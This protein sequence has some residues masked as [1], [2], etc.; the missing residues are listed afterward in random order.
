MGEVTEG[1]RRVPMRVWVAVFVVFSFVCSGGF[2][3][4]DMV[5]GSGPGFVL[6]LLMILPFVWG[7]PQALVCS[8]LGSAL[9]EDGGLYRWSRRANGEFMG[10]QTGWWWVLSIFVDS[11]VYIALTC[12]YMQ[13]WFGF[14]DWVRWGIA[15]GLIAIFAYINI[16]GIQLAASVLIVFQVIVFIPF[17]ALAVIGIANWHHNPFSV[18]LLP[19]NSLLGGVGVALSV[20]IWMYSGF[21][22]LST[23]AGEIER[24][25]KVIPRALMITLPIVIGF[26]VLS[27]LGGLADVGRYT[28]WGTSGALD[29]MGVGRVVGGQI[30]RYLFFAAMFAGN[31]ALFLAFLAAGARPSFTLSKDKLLPKFLSKTH[32]KYGTPFAAILLMAGVDCILVRSGF[33]TLIVIDVFLLMLAHITIY[34]SAIRL[35]VNEPDMERPFK[36]GLKTPAFIAMCAVPITVAVFAM[37]PWGNGWNYFIWGT[38]AALTGPPAYFIFKRIYGGQRALDAERA[39]GG[40]EPPAA[41]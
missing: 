8:E 10:F 23:M 17:A 24:P 7:L 22:S 34:I 26:Y 1:L 27:T 41:G 18:M 9:P 14:N 38:V 19:G 13:N 33:S 5:S 36:V 30:L 35:R 32:R 11:A 6:L 2:G 40:E 31:F 16:R 37:S 12:D 29:F 4:E 3:I 21:E 15:V 20:G 25:Q 39:A 28:E